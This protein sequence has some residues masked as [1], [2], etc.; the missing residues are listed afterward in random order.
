MSITQVK[1]WCIF[2]LWLC[3]HWNC[4]QKNASKPVDQHFTG[5]LIQRL[6]VKKSE[7]CN[8]LLHLWCLFIYLSIY[9][10]IYIY[11]YLSVYLLSIYTIMHI[12]L[13]CIISYTINYMYVY[14]LFYIIRP[15]T[16]SY[17]IMTSYGTYM[18][19]PCSESSL[20][21]KNGATNGLIIPSM[22]L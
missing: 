19:T 15:L 11:I 21:V 8:K 2:H 12:H 6:S 7:L 16:T 10:S 4:D 3:L 13:T 9:L 14:V 18:S 22:G 17:H 20:P 5:H 1:K